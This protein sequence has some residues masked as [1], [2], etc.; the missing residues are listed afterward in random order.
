M[1]KIEIRDQALTVLF[2]PWARLFTRRSSMTVPLASIREIEHL[3]HPLRAATGLHAGMRMSG[4]AKVGAWISLRGVKR[5]VAAR[6][7]EP[8]VRIVLA[9]RSSG[10]DELILSAPAPALAEVRR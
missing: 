5:L 6:R 8:G 4:V 9:D 10:Y 7:G 1:I 2:A 3:D